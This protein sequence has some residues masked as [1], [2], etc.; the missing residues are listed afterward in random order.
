V[1]TI[2]GEMFG[3]FFEKYEFRLALEY[4][5]REKAVIEGACVVKE[6]G[7]YC[8]QQVKC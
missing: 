8:R 2:G 4:G 7:D 3:D 1:G 6:L 5:G